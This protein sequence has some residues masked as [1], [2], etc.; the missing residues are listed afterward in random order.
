MKLYPVML[1]VSG[2]RVLVIGGGTVA[3]RKIRDLISCGARVTV[4]APEVHASVDELAS[5]HP[6]NL[7]II[8]RRYRCGDLEGALMVF[9]AT[10]D[11]EVNH[12]VFNEAKEKN[13]FINAGDDPGNC[14]FYVPSW[15]TRGGLVVAVSTGGI[16]PAMAER[17]RRVIEGL[18]PDAFG[19]TL[20]ALQQARTILQNDAE[21][22]GLTA[23]QRGKILK[24]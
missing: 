3:L 1:N 24:K 10:V 2:K 21:F 23:E 11:D 14:T 12:A 13:I 15:F 19:E 18:I 9:S 6:E 16:S 20:D 7:E 4:V 22:T 5:S 17:L 8:R